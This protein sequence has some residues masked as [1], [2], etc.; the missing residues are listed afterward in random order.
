MPL[1]VFLSS[2]LRKY[3]SQY[4]PVE[5]IEFELE[6]KST[7]AEICRKI[8]VPVEQIKVIMVNGRN[9]ELDFVLKG[10]ER[11]GLFPSIGGG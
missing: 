11:I 4:N 8:N 5:G 9:A 6:D 7:V 10:N 1:K 3:V 2:S